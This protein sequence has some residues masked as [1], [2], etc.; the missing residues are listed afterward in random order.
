[1]IRNPGLSSLW[2]LS[3][4]PSMLSL[5]ARRPH[6]SRSFSLKDHFPNISLQ[7]PIR[8]RKLIFA[9][10]WACSCRPEGVACRSHS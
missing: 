4:L 9:A 1:M 8:C 2:K 6:S 7:T 10:A 5:V 3:L